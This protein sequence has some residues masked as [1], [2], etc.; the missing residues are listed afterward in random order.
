M[1]IDSSQTGSSYGVGMQGLQEPKSPEGGNVEGRQPPQESQK[2]QVDNGMKA[3]GV[4]GTLDTQ[5]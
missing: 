5:G 3:L 4:G 2:P 1:T